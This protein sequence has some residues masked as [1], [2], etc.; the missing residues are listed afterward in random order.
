MPE[1]LAADAPDTR[2]VKAFN[3]IPHKVIELERE[4]LVSHRVSVFL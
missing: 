3:R 2:V 4:K 1:R